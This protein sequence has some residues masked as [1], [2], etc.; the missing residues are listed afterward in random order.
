MEPER[1]M[2]D[3]GGR[4]VF[5]GGGCETQHVLPL[6]SPEAIREHVRENVRAFG[7]RQGGFV[8]TQVHNIQ[9]NVPVRN[10]IAMLDAAYEYG[11]MP[12]GGAAAS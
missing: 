2:R 3:F 4:V 9:P 10:V 5:W 8:F 6:E 12:S 1:L 11:T 7:G